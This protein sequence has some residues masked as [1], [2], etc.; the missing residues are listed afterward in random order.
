MKFK[1]PTTIFVALAVIAVSFPGIFAPEKAGA[2]IGAAASAVSGA[3]GSG[4]SAASAVSGVSASAGI[5]LGASAVGSVLSSITGPLAFEINPIMLAG[6]IA[7]K[8]TAVSTAA[9]AGTNA[10]KLSQS[11]LEWAKSFALS[12]LKRQILDVMVDQIVNWI[13]NGGE[14]R[15]VADWD[16]FFGDVAQGA[17][18]EFVQEIGAGFLCSPFSLQVRASLLPVEKFGRNSPYSCTLDKIVGNVEDFYKDFR[19]G[20]WIAYEEAG[21]LQNNY[22]GALWLS[23]YGRDQD[24]ASK[25]AAANAKINANSGFLSV[26]LCRDAKTG[27]II[28]GDEL[29]QLQG[30]DGAYSLRGGSAKK[31]TTISGATGIVCE[32]TTP[33]SYVGATLEKAAGVDFDYIVNAQQLGNYAAAIT[34]ALINRVIKEG[35]NG[36]RGVT[37]GQAQTGD[38]QAYL[39]ESSLPNSLQN[40]GQNYLSNNFVVAQSSLRDQIT[41]A[42]SYRKEVNFSYATLIDREKTILASLNSL[43]VC[44]ATTF[45]A[46]EQLKTSTQNDIKDQ[47]NA[48]ANIQTNADENI[49]EIELL[50]SNLIKLSNLTDAQASAAFDSASLAQITGDINA[51]SNLR[52]ETT[53]LVEISKANF[54]ERNNKVLADVKQYCPKQ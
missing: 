26:Q 29:A 7:Q 12:V 6:A 3:I 1:T 25:L 4:A 33:G 27:Q 32:D 50:K 17:V 14:P 22:Y 43:N 31:F 54:E 9:T 8:A 48:I 36:L 42:I 15:F 28:S 20:G 19:N 37:G 30:A 11:L 39:R 49:S 40:S 45:F 52:N 16:R 18:D 10:A 35:V 24:V 47:K 21:K 13:Q 46:P 5:G 53:S 41:T 51:A 2:Q 34:N 38:T 44:L 23:W